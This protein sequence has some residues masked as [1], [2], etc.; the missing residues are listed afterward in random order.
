MGDE[1]KP[2][3]AWQELEVVVD[4][5][6][7]EG[8]VLTRVATN[9]NGDAFQWDIEAVRERI[10]RMQAEAPT[11]QAPRGILAPGARAALGRVD[12]VAVAPRII[13]VQLMPP[14]SP[15]V[16]D[17]ETADRMVRHNEAVAAASMAA[18]I[19]RIEMKEGDVLGVDVV[20]T[21]AP[22]PIED[23]RVRGSVTAAGA[24]VAEALEAF[25]EQMDRTIDALGPAE[26]WT[27]HPDGSRSFHD[28]ALSDAISAAVDRALLA[29]F[30]GVQPGVEGYFWFE[31]DGADGAEKRV[32]RRVVRDGSGGLWTDE[33]GHGVRVTQGL[34]ARCLGPVAPPQGPGAEQEALLRTNALVQRV[35]GDLCARLE[36]MMDA[37][38]VPPYGPGIGSTTERVQVALEAYAT[39][40]AAEGRWDAQATAIRT[41][42]DA[43][44][45]PDWRPYTDAELVEYQTNSGVVIPLVDRVKALAARA[46]L[47]AMSPPAEALRADAQETA[48]F[49]VFDA[50]CLLTGEAG[51]QVPPSTLAEWAR[52]VLESLLRADVG[53]AI[54]IL[55]DADATL[56]MRMRERREALADHVHMVWARWMAWQGEHA[57]LIA[58]TTDAEG[59]AGL[60]WGHEAIAQWYRQAKTPYAELP[61]PEKN[62]DR[63]IADEYLAILLGRC[64]A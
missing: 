19:A 55:T 33:G 7:P 60:A 20:L 37:V 42:C 47:T 16:C 48:A 43:A 44:L 28:D 29:T 62:S 4:P 23:L 38:G 18:E 31:E 2:G 12:Y 56:R 46:H 58:L 3:Q 30:E 36:A 17:R 45:V 13:D 61:E 21:Q 27:T 10:R 39:L 53:W 64:E 63:A 9:A 34:A 6:L 32:V 14:A 5:H 52:R 8:V 35:V 11:Y 50:L 54:G 1:R 25:S 51:L 26:G 49:A 57:G 40:R 59:G 22:E 24:Q 15:M 41:I